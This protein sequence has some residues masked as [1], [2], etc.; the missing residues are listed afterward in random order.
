MRYFFYI[1]YCVPSFCPTG[2]SPKLFVQSYFCPNHFRP[3]SKD[4]LGWT[5][6][7]QKKEWTIIGLG[8]KWIGQIQGW[9]KTA[10]DKMW[11]GENRLDQNELDE[12]LVYRRRM[13]SGK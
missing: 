9:T 1:V 10:L 3:N 2:F 11:L 5:K 12:K 13:N 7:G 4:R 6:I 8:R